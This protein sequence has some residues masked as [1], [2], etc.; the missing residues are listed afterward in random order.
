MP[1]SSVVLR[2]NAALKR[3]VRLA[4]EPRTRINSDRQRK[5]DAFKSTTG[6]ITVSVTKSLEYVFYR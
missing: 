2:P 1:S 5:R 6:T 4:S 3:S